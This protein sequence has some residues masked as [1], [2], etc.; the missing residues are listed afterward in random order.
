[1]LDCGEG[2]QLAIRRHKIPLQ[3]I[4]HIFIS[5]LHGDHYF[6]LIGYLSS[7][8]LLGRKKEIHVYGPGELE[9]ILDIQLKASQTQLIYP[10]VF[11]EV[12]ANIVSEIY[13]D[14]QLSITSYPMLHRI[15][16][17]GFIFAELFPSKHLRADVIKMLKIPYDQLEDIRKGAN[18]TDEHGYVHTNDRITI[19]KSDARKY[20]FFSD[21]ACSFKYLDLIEKADLVYHEATFMDCHKQAA[22]EKYHSTAGQAGQIALAAQAKKLIIGHFS[23]RYKNTDGLLNEASEIFK[24]TLVAS[25]GS[26]FNI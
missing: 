20:V 12:N 16:T 4:D 25:E 11:H 8:H 21:T 15:A 10:L 18:Y 17:T 6:G 5:H 19:H 3:S 23:A 9:D 14:G 2:T 7:L 13:N 26:V 22:I 24:N 1:M